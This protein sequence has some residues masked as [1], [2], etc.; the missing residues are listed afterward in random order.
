MASTKPKNSADSRPALGAASPVDEIVESIERKL[1]GERKRMMKGMD[2][3]KKSDIIRQTT[4]KRVSDAA[5]YADRGGRGVGSANREQ[6]EYFWSAGSAVAR[7]PPPRPATRPGSGGNS[8]GGGTAAVTAPETQQK[9]HTTATREK[10][11]A[12]KPPAST[13]KADAGRHP[14][15]A[16]Q[17]GGSPHKI[18]I[19][20]D[21]SVDIKFQD[22]EVPRRHVASQ[23]KSVAFAYDAAAHPLHTVVENSLSG[24]P[25]SSSSSSSSSASLSS[26][27]PTS[28]LDEGLREERKLQEQSLRNFWAER[29]EINKQFR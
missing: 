14:N 22:D 10:M 28:A 21:G 20:R 16:Q 11:S 6:T 29:K 15:G 24:N 9:R 3:A 26:F 25:K 13:G 23:K 17:P 19:H 7:R 12:V 5:A 2:Q 27:R 1:K 18:K 4:L 8:G